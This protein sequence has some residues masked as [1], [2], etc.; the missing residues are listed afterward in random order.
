[1]KIKIPTHIRPL[2]FWLLILFLTHLNFPYPPTPPPNSPPTPNP[3]PP[4]AP[5]HPYHHPPS[6]YTPHTPTPLTYFHLPHSLHH[7]LHHTTPPPFP[8]SL[9]KNQTPP[10]TQKFVAHTIWTHHS[11]PPHVHIHLPSLPSLHRIKLKSYPLWPTVGTKSQNV[12]TKSQNF[13]H[14]TCIHLPLHATLVLTTRT[15]PQSTMRFPTMLSNQPYA[16]RIKSCPNGLVGFLGKFWDFLGFVP[17][18]GQNPK[19]FVG[20]KSQ[21]LA[22][23]YFRL[24]HWFW[25][26]LTPT[27][28]HALSNGTQHSPVR[29]VIKVLSQRTFGIF[30]IL[31]QRWDKFV[32]WDKIPKGFFFP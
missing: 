26:L 16:F 8:L 27:I 1:M 11:T 14:P 7:S 17:T 20:T 18:L 10:T 29:C 9:T 5:M 6:H 23:T 2:F 22:L 15:P 4:T 12:G 21:K 32:G 30:G 24:A 13:F 25:P 3:T 31:S 28:N 19:T